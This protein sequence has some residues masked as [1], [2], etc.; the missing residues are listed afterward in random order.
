ML[1]AR[2]GDRAG[3]DAVRQATRVIGIPRSQEFSG[4]WATLAPERAS[5]MADM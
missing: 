5:P 1:P 4:N 3:T 2:A